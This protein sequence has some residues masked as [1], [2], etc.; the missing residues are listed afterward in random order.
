MD[1]VR[2]RDGLDKS[3]VAERLQHCRVEDLV[4]EFFQSEKLSLLPENELG[5]ALRMFVEKDDKDAIKQFDF[6]P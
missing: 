1:E 3:S 4:F 5:N 6:P 2:E